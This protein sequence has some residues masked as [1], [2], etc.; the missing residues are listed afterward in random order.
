LPAWIVEVALLGLAIILAC[1]W[2]GLG[3]TWFKAAERL[4]GRLARRKSLAVLT[5][6]ATALAARLALLPLMSVPEPDIHDEFSHLLAADTFASGRATN[7]SPVMWPHFESFHII[8]RPTYMSMY[9]PAQGLVLGVGTCLGHPWTG[10]LLSVALMFAAICWMLQGWFSPGW[11]FLGG[12]LAVLRFGLTG[13]WINSYMGGAVAAT[14]GALILGAF[15]RLVR[16]ARIQHALLMAL[17]LVLLANSRPYEGL[18]LSLPIGLTLLGQLLITRRGGG[19][20][21]ILRTLLPIVLVLTLAGFAMGYYFWRVTGSPVR[22]PYEVN[23]ATYATAPI[24]LWQSPHPDPAYRHATMRDFYDG[25]ERAVYDREIQTPYNL[26]ILKVAFAIALLAFY[27]GPTLFLPIIMRPRTL[28]DRRLRLLSIAGATH[29]VGLTVEVFF[30]PHYA[31]PMTAIILALVIQALRHLRLWRWKNQPA[32]TF[33]VRTLPLVCAG[34]LAIRLLASGLGLPLTETNLWWARLMPSQRGLERAHVL[35]R[36]ERMP[37][38]H[39]VIVRYRPD[40]DP[41]Q[42]IEWVY[43][44]ADIDHAKVIWARDMGPAQNRPLL[45]HYRG[46]H[47]WILETHRQPVDLEPYPLSSPDE[48]HR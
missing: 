2:P 12:M 29:L 36:L 44:R 27:F 38:R 14:G 5:V 39:L 10:V 3:S 25:L 28:V 48:T 46:R 42:Q 9:P 37:G 15:P 20:I 35:A 19:N 41:I 18:V 11:A 17:G 7:P 26:I 21:R 22:L 1:L 8:V 33:L 34:T 45:D 30:L 6:A 32:G 4:L 31:A 40:Y 23:R 47:V 24:F 43:N 16:T 13:Y